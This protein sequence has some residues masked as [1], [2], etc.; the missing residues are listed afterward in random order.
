[1]SKGFVVYSPLCE[2][3][4]YFELPQ[5]NVFKTRGGGQAVQFTD[6]ETLRQECAMASRYSI[7]PKYYRL[8]YF[9]KKQIDR[10]NILAIYV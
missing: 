3:F 6:I 5:G 10:I 8:R 2:F 9:C 1:M 7:C 4:C